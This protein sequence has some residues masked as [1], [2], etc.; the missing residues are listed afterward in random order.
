M[1][2]I[3]TLSVPQQIGKK[4]FFLAEVHTEAFLRLADAAVTLSLVG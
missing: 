2:T 4:L 1:W 3:S